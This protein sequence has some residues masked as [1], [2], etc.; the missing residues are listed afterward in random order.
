M[1]YKITRN[2]FFNLTIII[3]KY[4]YV[5]HIVGFREKYYEYIT[6]M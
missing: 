5:I 1:N 3:R 6:Q 2:S 4:V